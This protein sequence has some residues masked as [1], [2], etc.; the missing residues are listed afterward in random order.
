LHSAFSGLSHVDADRPFAGVAFCKMRRPGLQRTLNTLGVENASRSFHAHREPQQ[1]TRLGP[2]H[3]RPFFSI[4]GRTFLV[5]LPSV[6]GGAG[7]PTAVRRTMAL[8]KGSVLAILLRP[9]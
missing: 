2:P 3:N 7:R 9:L 1:S 8:A 4:Q 5:R 6:M